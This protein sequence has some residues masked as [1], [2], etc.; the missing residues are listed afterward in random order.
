MPES[1]SSNNSNDSHHSDLKNSRRF[2]SE[3][4]FYS[5]TVEP[6]YT[7]TR[8]LPRLTEVCLFIALRIFF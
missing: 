3:E 4:S 1:G 6:T 8:D 2:S 5:P 7:P